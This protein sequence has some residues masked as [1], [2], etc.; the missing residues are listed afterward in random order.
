MHATLGVQEWPKP[1]KKALMSA[2]EMD[3]DGSLSEFYPFGRTFAA[4]HCDFDP[5]RFLLHRFFLTIVF[6][7]FAR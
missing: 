6:S 1:A 5:R 2:S 3:R 4:P 7:A